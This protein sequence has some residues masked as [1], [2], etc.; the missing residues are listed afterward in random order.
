[1]IV[2]RCQRCGAERRNKAALDDPLQPDDYDALMRLVAG[3]PHP[4]TW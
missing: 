2:H 4:S 1:V 3:V